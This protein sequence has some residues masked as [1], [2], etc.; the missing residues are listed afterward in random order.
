MR[1]STLTITGV[2]VLLTA[3]LVYVATQ[4]LLAQPTAVFESREVDIGEV[5]QGQLVEHSFRLRNAG[6][7][8]LVIDRLDPGCNCTSARA[9]SSRMK[10]GQNGLVAVNVRTDR[11]LGPMMEQVIV[12]TNDPHNRVVTLKVKSLV[13]AE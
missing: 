4:R 3:G 2:S 7:A 10:P 1:R 13:R 11:S 12:H 6:S 8:D 5:L 9:S